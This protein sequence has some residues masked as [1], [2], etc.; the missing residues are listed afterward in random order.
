MCGQGNPSRRARSLQIR[1]REIESVNAREAMRR[2]SGR[3]TGGTDK[4][5]AV[6]MTP[7]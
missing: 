5:E 7:L 2:I 3:A 4:I 6:P 1:R